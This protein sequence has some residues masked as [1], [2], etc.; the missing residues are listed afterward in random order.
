MLPGA[1]GD[2]GFVGEEKWRGVKFSGVPWLSER[3]R[4]FRSVLSGSG[5]GFVIVKNP[6]CG[7]DYN[8]VGVR[9]IISLLC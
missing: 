9:L 1:T 7:Y 6:S 5:S 8:V 3:F 4:E 2:F